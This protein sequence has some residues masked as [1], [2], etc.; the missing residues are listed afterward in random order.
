MT[1]SPALLD[2]DSLSE[3]SRGHPRVSERAAAYLAR[4][5]RLTLSAVTVFERLRGYRTAIRKGNPFQAQLRQF[6]MLAA[7][8]LVLPVDA[9]VA[10]LAATIWA[11]LPA[12]RRRA[13]ADIL[14]AATACA[15]RL[16]LVTRNRR[17]FEPITRIEGIALSLLDW[18]RAAR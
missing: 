14:I 18:S 12:R 10:D 16:P 7:S 9:S 4:H 5:G 17:D 13:T 1:D 2:S 15:H 6:E 8:S 11:D 3:L